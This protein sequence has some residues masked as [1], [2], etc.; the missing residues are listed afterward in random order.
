MKWSFFC[1]EGII[2]ENNRHKQRKIIKHNYFVANLIIIYT[3]RLM[4]RAL[5]ELNAEG[6]V[7]EPALLK[8]LAPYRAQPINRFG[9][10]KLNLDKIVEPL[11]DERD[12]NLKLNTLTSTA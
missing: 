8:K 11:L 12:L 10:Y 6:Y 1:G 9:S 4:T 5:N 2:T 7:I 3:M